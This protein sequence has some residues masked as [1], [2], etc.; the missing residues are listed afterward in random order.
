MRWALASI[1][2]CAALAWLCQPGTLAT[3]RASARL[4]PAPL[5]L[6]GYAFRPGMTRSEAR[7]LWGE[8][9]FTAPDGG[10]E[11][12]AY[13]RTRLYFGSEGLLTATG[14]RLSRGGQDLL[15]QGDHHSRLR[16]GPEWQRGYSNRTA[17]GRLYT[18]WTCNQPTPVALRVS[19][20]EAV[21]SIRLAVLD[22]RVASR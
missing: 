6:D 3:A 4:T 5:E 1:A 7:R 16:L 15:L 8:P 2:L 12:W 21:Q 19:H 10:V 18:E 20:D 17:P 13:G 22:E 9:Q 11:I 14:T